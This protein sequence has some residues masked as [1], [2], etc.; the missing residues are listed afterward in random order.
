[1]LQEKHMSLKI[2]GILVLIIG[3]VMGL[4]LSLGGVLLN[5]R[6]KLNSTELSQ[7]HDRLF[8]EVIQSVKRE[9]VEQIDDSVLLESA[10]R[11]MVSKLD[12]YSQ[13]LDAEQFK[14][15]RMSTTGSY[16]GVG[17]V[18]STE[19]GV[20]TVVPP[21]NDTPAERAGMLNGDRIIAIDDNLVDSAHLYETIAKIRGR[22]GTRVIITVTREG[23]Q[24]PIVFDLRRE[25]IQIE[26][27]RHEIL[28]SAIGYVRIS[29]FIE[30]T[31]NALNHAID[32]MQ[33]QSD[34]MLDGLI[35]DLRNNPGG[36]L[37]SAI[38]VS[39]L[40]LN[41]GVIVTSEGR[42]AESRFTK[43]AHQG[44]MLDGT[45]MVVLVNSGSASASE[46]VA[47]ALQDN[48]RAMIVG[49]STF[50]KGVVQTVVPLSKGRAIKLTTSRFYTPS[51]DAIHEKGIFPDIVI[52]DTRKP[53]EISFPISE[54]REYDAQ[55]TQ[56]LLLL[57]PKNV[58]QSKSE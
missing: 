30:S 41:T 49:T 48:N 53:S 14:N 36:V 16:S 24:N 34:G 35:L 17:L 55:L 46:I 7:G 32:D 38:D 8:T 42:T 6:D 2:R 54:D 26:S 23:E 37:D 44:D 4:S 39:D 58:M 1:M 56:A 19:D 13:Y 43:E 22:A 27:V 5:K 12:S 31:A 47:G 29:Q 28:Q 10:I 57:T 25:S 51:G 11:G 50:G 40:F 45:D 15:I 52:E 33:D 9:Y 3:T 18:V 20:I 21:I